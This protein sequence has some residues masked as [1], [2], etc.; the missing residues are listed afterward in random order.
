[1]AAP[2]YVYVASSDDPRPVWG[3]AP[4]RLGNGSWKLWYIPD[5]DSTY[6][7]TRTL[8][9]IKKNGG[10]NGFELRLEQD[11]GCKVQVLVDDVVVVERV[12]TFSAN[13]RLKITVDA[14]T[15]LLRVE[16]ATTGNGTSLG[17]VWTVD[18][19]G[20][21]WRTGTADSAA[22]PARGYVSLPYG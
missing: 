20:A 9:W 13:Q 12:V 11:S 7:T 8:L 2:H 6:G 16:G 22:T 17:T 18:A 4:A 21:E 19:G 1:M 15:G 10:G 5:D 14:A 3:E